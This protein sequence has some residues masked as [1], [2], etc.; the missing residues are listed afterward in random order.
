LPL[1]LTINFDLNQFCEYIKALTVL[2]AN[3][4]QQGSNTRPPMLK[5][6]FEAT[7]VMGMDKTSFAIWANIGNL[8]EFIFH[9]FKISKVA[10]GFLTSSTKYR[11]ICDLF[12]TSLLEARNL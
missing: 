10:F 11:S 8:V 9:Q 5:A 12:S 1:P 7:V 4:L 3:E 6:D 2:R